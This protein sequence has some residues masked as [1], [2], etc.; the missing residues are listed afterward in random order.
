MSFDDSD[1]PEPRHP[2][3]APGLPY[4]RIL[5]KVSGEAL[6][7]SEPFGLHP[8]TVALREAALS[9]DAELARAAD[10]LWGSRESGSPESGMGNGE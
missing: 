2:Y 3:A 5:V 6:M 10:K 9:G 1:V 8:P 4:P 7:G